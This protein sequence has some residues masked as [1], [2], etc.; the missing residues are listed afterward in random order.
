MYSSIH[1]CIIVIIIIFFLE[2]FCYSENFRRMAL[3]DASDKSFIDIFLLLLISNKERICKGNSYTLQRKKNIYRNQKR[4][5]QILKRLELPLT[6]G[7]G[8]CKGG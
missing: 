6:N 7:V 1:W 8:E 3:G 5:M 4:T 2:F